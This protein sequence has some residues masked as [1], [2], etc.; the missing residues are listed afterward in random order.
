M[1]TIESIA[2]DFVEMNLVERRAMH[3][4]LGLGDVLKN[5]ERGLFCDLVNSS[6]PSISLVMSARCR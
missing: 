2:P 6:A 4:G 5:F 1:S 3:A